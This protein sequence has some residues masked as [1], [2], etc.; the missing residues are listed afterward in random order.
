MMMVMVMMVMKTAKSQVFFFV[1]QILFAP[2]P[3]QPPQNKNNVR[4]GTRK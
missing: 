4:L 2:S 3:T 1:F